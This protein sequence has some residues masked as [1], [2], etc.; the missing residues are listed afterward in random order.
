MKL[1]GFPPAR[2]IRALWMLRELD[3]DF[4]YVQ[5][6][7]TKGEHRRPEFLAVNPAGKIPVLIDDDLV[8]SE[9]VAIV[10][11]LAEKHPQK[12]FLPTDLRVRA[13]VYRWLLFTEHGA[14]ARGLAES[15]GV[16]G[17]DVRTA[18]GTAAH[19]RGVREPPRLRSHTSKL[20]PS[21]A[22]I[23]VRARPRDRREPYACGSTRMAVLTDLLR[24]RP[25]ERLRGPVDEHAQPPGAPD[26]SPRR[27]RASSG[28][29][30]SE[31]S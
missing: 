8:L 20:R 19:R 24:H 31:A 25:R 9:S 23:A 12:G 29:P 6:D 27:P 26:A 14:S 11:Y 15:A 16:H 4:E 2:T 21:A 28:A 22:C 7:P 5:V 1:Y 17:A 13:E 3:L 30:S 10:L 18:P